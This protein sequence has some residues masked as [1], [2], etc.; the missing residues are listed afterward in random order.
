MAIPDPN[1]AN[2]YRINFTL[3][4]EGDYYGAMNLSG[5]GVD[6]GNSVGI[7]RDGE[8][9]IVTGSGGGGPLGSVVPW[10]EVEGYT[11]RAQTQSLVRGQ[12]QHRVVGDNTKWRISLRADDVLALVDGE[13]VRI[14]IPGNANAWL[15][16]T[17]A[18]TSALSSSPGATLLLDLENITMGSG[19]NTATNTGWSIYRVGNVLDRVF[20]DTTVENGFSL[21]GAG[22][23]MDKMVLGV[24]GKVSAAEIAAGTEA[25]VRLMSPADVVAIIAAHETGGGGGG[26]GGLASVATDATLTGDGTTGSPLSVADPFTDAYKV[27]LDGIQAGAQMNE[28]HVGLP[29]RTEDGSSADSA[30]LVSFIKSDNT[31]W[32][33]G[34]STQVAA[35]EIHPDQYT[36]AQNPQSDNASYT[37]WNEFAEDLIQNGG[38]SIWTFQRISVS[39]EGSALTPIVG[40][41]MQVQVDSLTKNSDNNYVL[42]T[43]THLSGFSTSG[44][45]YN[46]QV[47]SVFAPPVGADSVIG[48]LRKTQLPGDVVYT[49]QLQG[50]EDDLY[51]SYTNS[52]SDTYWI[53]TMKFFNQTSGAPNNANLIRQPDIANG[54]ITVAVGRP[55]TDRDPDHFVQ[56]AEQQAS[57]YVAGQVYYIGDYDDPNVGGVLTLTSGGTV[58]GT[59][60]SR[61]IYF[62]ATLSGVTSELTDVSDRGDY[63]RFGKEEPTK[64]KI[65]IPTADVLGGDGRWFRVDGTN[66]EQAT[67][68]AIQGDNETVK[69]GAQ[70]RVDVTNVDYYVSF[71]EIGG[72][73]TV[74][75]RIPWGST[76]TQQAQQISADLARLLKPAAWLQ[77]GDFT[78]DITTNY[79]LA[80][81]GTSRTFTANYA[82]V[83]DGTVPTGS[84]L[85]D[86]YVVGEDVHRGQIARQG[87]KEESPSIGGKGGTAGQVWTRGSGDYNA[88][89]EDSAAGLPDQSGHNGQFLR[90]DGSAADWAT[91]SLLNEYDSGTQTDSTNYTN[92]TD[93]NAILMP[94]IGKVGV[95]ET[96]N[97]DGFG[98]VYKT[99]DLLRL[100]FDY[101]VN[102]TVG[103]AIL[104]RYSDTKPTSG[105]NART[106]GTQALSVSDGSQGSFTAYDQPTDRYWWLALSVVNGT[107]DLTNRSVRIRANY[108][109]PPSGV[110]SVTGTDPISAVTTNGNSV[111]S[112]GNVNANKVRHAVNPKT[113]DYTVTASDRGGTIL[114][115]GTFTLTL[116]DISATDI[117]VGFWFNIVNSGTG[118]V[119]IQSHTGQMIDGSA[120]MAAVGSNEIQALTTTAW[121]I[122]C[123]RTIVTD[124]SILDL[125][126]ETR[127]TADR[128][129]VLGVASDNE[130]E[131][132]LVTAP[133]GGGGLSVSGVDGLTQR[134]DTEGLMTVPGVVGGQQKPVYNSSKNLTNSSVGLG[135]TSPSASCSFV[136]GGTRYEL[137]FAFNTRNM[138]VRKGGTGTV[139]TATNQ[140]TSDN[141]NAAAA[142]AVVLSNGTIRIVVTDTSDDKAFLYTYNTSDDTLTAVTN[143]N[144]QS[145]NGHPSACVIVPSGTGYRVYVGDGV[146]AIAYAYTATATF[147]TITADSSNNIT[148]TASNIQ[149]MCRAEDVFYIIAT[150]STTAQAYTLTGERNASLDFDRD[151][152]NYHAATAYFDGTAI[153]IYDSSDSIF[154][155]YDAIFPRV[156]RKDTIPLLSPALSGYRIRALTNSFADVSSDTYADSDVLVITADGANGSLMYISTSIIPFSAISGT[157]TILELEASGSQQTEIKIKKSGSKLQAEKDTLLDSGVIHVW[158]IGVGS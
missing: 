101:N 1:T 13:Q 89:W 11:F 140:L 129:K 94:S 84:V 35:I 45:G 25:E 77:V 117:G 43:L 48:V 111:V 125:A 100:I 146:D 87:F 3:A 88:G 76:P 154:Y 59:G 62:T 114:C 112:L 120:S 116:P 86:A 96:E 18:S 34:S 109:A 134:G 113:A 110:Q 42:G 38:M 51:F 33:S 21:S 61:R 150:S 103:V 142:D 44:S 27:K 78:M 64:I 36:L 91:P 2:S 105:D 8:K 121:G 131:L 58:V 90:T 56:G 53:G 133:S 32:Q 147:T 20:L 98:T 12:F 136:S 132:A 54:S 16:G 7:R 138:Y 143:V 19:F 148:G 5:L 102:A 37:D 124:D 123:D 151:S 99:D 28:R 79:T 149:A 135:S 49:E 30:G 14:A 15:V 118:T 17:V 126:Q 141:T 6:W 31:Q 152:A 130:N 115:N 29:F 104:L 65:D 23:P 50:K 106:F 85:R 127:T 68:D 75:V 128:G 83:G 156:L 24:P 72:V 122:T 22:V 157:G 4:R 155:A 39:G 107:R 63:W 9:L 92:Q 10:G 153:F 108:V 145:A 74:R 73:P 66:V 95:V 80:T 137:F 70:F 26:G 144:L 57:D 81:I 67:K 119:T 41:R 69:L 46:W 139:S 97:I 82:V 52:A 40:D 93:D 47:V 71:S 55:R 158:K 60:N